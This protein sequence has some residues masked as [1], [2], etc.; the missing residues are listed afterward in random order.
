MDYNQSALRNELLRIN[1]LSDEELLEKLI[2]EEERHSPYANIE[3]AKNILYQCI[4]RV[5]E[6]LVELY[7]QHKHTAN[8]SVDFAL[9]LIPVLASNS[10]IPA[11][12]IPVLAILIIRHSTEFLAEQ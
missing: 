2:P 9:Y 11:H 3:R 10:T 12:L 5:K 6:G 7:N 8:F 1:E 4:S